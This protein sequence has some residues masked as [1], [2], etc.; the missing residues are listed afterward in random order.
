MTS[1]ILLSSFDT[2]QKKIAETAT[3]ITRSYYRR[4]KTKLQYL[5]IGFSKCISVVTRWILKQSTT[6]EVY[7]MLV[8]TSTE[9]DSLDIIR[10]SR[11]FLTI[12]RIYFPNSLIFN[13]S[14]PSKIE[15]HGVCVRLTPV[16]WRGMEFLEIV[17]G[18]YA[19]LFLK[20]F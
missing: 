19:K 11:Y 17:L 18:L 14:N 8:G 1:S 20:A 7:L 2:F 3:S 9:L 4:R 10:N 12:K 5:D 16:I 13:R 6:S 15:S